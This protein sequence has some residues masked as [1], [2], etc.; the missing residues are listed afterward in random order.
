MEVK[1]VDPFGLVA[2]IE[3]TEAITVVF[4]IIIDEPPYFSTPLENL[5]PV[6]A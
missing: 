5:A 3:L 2:D 6:I 4:T 1:L